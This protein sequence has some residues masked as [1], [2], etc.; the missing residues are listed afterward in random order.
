[1]PRMARK[2]LQIRAFLFMVGEDRVVFAIKT[3]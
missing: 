2:T 1:M 3:T